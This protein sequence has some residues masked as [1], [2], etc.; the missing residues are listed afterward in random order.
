MTA[1][2]RRAQRGQ[3]ALCIGYFCWQAQIDKVARHRQMVRVLLLHVGDEIIQSVCRQN[4]L[5]ISAPIDIAKNALVGELP[6]GRF[7]QGAKVGV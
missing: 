1:I 5:A 4:T 3:P 2:C 7:G 6:G